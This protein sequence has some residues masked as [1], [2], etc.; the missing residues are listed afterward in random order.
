MTVRLKQA[1]LTMCFLA[2]VA[3]PLFARGM[4]NLAADSY[5]NVSRDHD[6]LELRED[7]RLHP[8]DA[9]S[10]NNLAWILSTAADAKWRNPVQ[11]LSHAEKSVELAPKQW[12]NWGTLGAALYRNSRWDEAIVALQKS[13]ELNPVGSVLGWFTLAM[14]HRQRDDLEEARAWYDKATQ[15]MDKND[16]NDDETL[17]FRAEAAELL[18]VKDELKPE[19]HDQHLQSG[20]AAPQSV[21]AAQKDLPPTTR[22]KLP[23]PPPNTD[24]K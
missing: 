8:T 22:D 14:C 7:V 9:K 24:V 11:A 15:W 10:H 17:R 20:Q 19:K 3:N 5:E 4:I 1:F 12:H 16:S 2:A 21:G 13:E 18:G 6:A 23:G